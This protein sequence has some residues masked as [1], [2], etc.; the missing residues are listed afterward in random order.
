MIDKTIANLSI[1]YTSKSLTKEIDSINY[2]NGNLC[3][4]KFQ[5]SLRMN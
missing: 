3:E 1:H 4:V 2:K 5:K